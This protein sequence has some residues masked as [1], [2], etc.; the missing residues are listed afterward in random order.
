M[1]VICNRNCVD[2]VGGKCVRKELEIGKTGLCQNFVEF[3]EFYREDNVVVMDKNGIPSIMVKFTRKPDVK[4]IHPMF[5]IGGEVYDEI[6]ISKY[7]NC[8]INGLAYSLPMQKPATDVTL[9]EAE[10]ACFD[11]GE[12]WHLMTAME[13]GFLANYSL[14]NGTLPHGNTNYGKYRGNQEEGCETYDGSRMLTGTGPDTWTHDH[15]AFGVEGLCGDIYEWMRGMR[16]MDGKLEIANNNDA[17]MP[18]DLSENS[19]LWLPVEVGE[20]SVYLV[21]EDGELRFT[22]EEPE[23]TDY[24]G[25]RW[26]DVKFDFNLP[27]VMKNLGLFVGEPETYIYADM[28]GERLPLC[29]GF[30]YDGSSAGVFHVSLNGPRSISYGNVGFRSAYYRKRK[31]E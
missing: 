10:K 18:I 5:I 15:T 4:P 8:I 20:E 21:V 1:N 13:H 19:S 9:E 30:W 22:T 24:D 23:D 6:F 31:T 7:K 25:C 28:N 16:L 17:A 26:K 27:E 11:K 2:A 12:G 14:E 3:R 29:G